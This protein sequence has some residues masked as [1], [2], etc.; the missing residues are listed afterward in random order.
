M[1]NFLPVYL[2]KQESFTPKK[3]KLSHGQDSTTFNQQMAPSWH[4]LRMKDYGKDRTEWKNTFFCPGLQS[5]AEIKSLNTYHY[6]FLP[7]RQLI[8]MKPFMHPVFLLNS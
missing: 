5:W 8:K 1:L 3:Y 6:I 7:L 2:D 4:N